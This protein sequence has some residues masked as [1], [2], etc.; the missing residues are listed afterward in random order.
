MG[1][2]MQAH[3]IYFMHDLSLNCLHL[4]FCPSHCHSGVTHGDVKHVGELI[5]TVQLPEIYE[6]RGCPEHTAILSHSW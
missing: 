3:C 2:N 6:A 1:H 4:Y 5:L